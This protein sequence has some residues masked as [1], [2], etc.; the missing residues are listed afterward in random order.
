MA[1]IDPV[2]ISCVTKHE[3]GSQTL[4]R[5]AKQLQLYKSPDVDGDQDQNDLGGGPICAINDTTTARN[6]QFSSADWRK[7]RAAVLICLFEGPQGELRV[8]LTKR[9]MK[10]SSYPGDVALPGGK[11]EE[12]DADDSAT[13]LREAME[14][15]GLDSSL[16]EV[17]AN[18]EPFISL[19]QLLKVIPVIGLLD[20]VEDFKPELNSDEVDSVFDVPLEM[21]LQ[22]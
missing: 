11:T 5:V 8:I 9:S 17:V 20:R 15:I 12:G 6:E 3:C 1:C 13:A 16:V 18:L 10:L 21:F 4:Q 14:E 2:V 22:V 19:Q 7:R